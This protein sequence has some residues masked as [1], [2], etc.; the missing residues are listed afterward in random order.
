MCSSRMNY[1]DRWVRRASIAYDDGTLCHLLFSLVFQMRSTLKDQL[2]LVELREEFETFT[3]SKVAREL[4]DFYKACLDREE[5]GDFFELQAVTTA[6]IDRLHTSFGDMHACL[7]GVV[8]IEL[9]A[10]GS[11]RHRASGTCLMTVVYLC[12]ICHTISW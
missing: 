1:R 6:I 5:I 4:P 9:V 2:S 8:S 12:S 7:I 3:E 11:H 10:S